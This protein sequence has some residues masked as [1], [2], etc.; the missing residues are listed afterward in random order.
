MY[1]PLM[2]SIDLGRML[3]EGLITKVAPEEV[4]GEW[5]PAITGKGC[6]GELAIPFIVGGGVK[7]CNYEYN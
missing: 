6:T 7:P 2:G 3:C 5:A 1:I 4:D